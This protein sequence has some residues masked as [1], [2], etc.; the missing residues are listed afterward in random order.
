MIKIGIT[1]GIGSGKSYVCKRLQDQGIPVYSCDDEAKRLMTESK[2]IMH[3]IT[4]LIGDNAYTDGQLNKPRI[5][6]FLFSDTHNAEKINAIVHP[7]VKQDFDA[8]AHRQHTDIVAQECAILFE[9]HFEDTVD[10]TIEVYA[11]THIRLQRAMKRDAATAEQ[12]QARMKQQMDE[13]TKRDKAD[14]CIVNDG[15]TD[16]DKEIS[17]VLSLIR[18]AITNKRKP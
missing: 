17:R 5:A 3:A 4:Q 8:W 9:S 18:K 7:V 11:P 16:I 2:A 12:I 14:F 6:S 13:E 10:Y 15:Q 1:G